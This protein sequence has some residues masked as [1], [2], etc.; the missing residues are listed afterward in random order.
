MKL[1][2]KDIR[3]LLEEHF[4]GNIV[5]QPIHLTD[6]TDIRPVAQLIRSAQIL[7]S[8]VSTE[9]R[10]LTRR[11]SGLHLRGLLHHD[12]PKNM[13]TGHPSRQGR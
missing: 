7:Q 3:L 11:D 1:D 4:S 10:S 5:Y 8:T 13:Q 12:A 2:I 6:T 9:P